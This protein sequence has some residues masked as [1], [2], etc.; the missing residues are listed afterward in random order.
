MADLQIA[1]KPRGGTGKGVVRKLRQAGWI[2][3][4]LYGP[5]VNVA[6]QVQQKELERLLKSDGARTALV[7]LVVQNGEPSGQEYQVLLK[8]VQRDPVLG[9]VLH[10]DFYAVPLDRPV[11]AT[12][13]LLFEGVEELERRG[14]IPAISER[15]VEVECLPTAIPRYFAVNVAELEEGQTITVGEL[16]VPQGVRILTDGD[17]G[18]VS[19]LAPREERE[20]EQTAAPAAEQPAE[21]ERVT[22]PRKAE[23][24][25]EQEEEKEE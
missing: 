1:V 7:R 25:E 8:E 20:E 21:P 18:V 10:V 11:R 2:P 15:E 9:Q 5:S 22:R 14:L 12:V 13:P 17:A 6:V 4:S 3:G 23:A 19:A 16:Q 24:E